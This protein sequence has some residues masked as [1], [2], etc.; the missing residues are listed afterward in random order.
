MDIHIGQETEIKPGSVLDKVRKHNKLKN[1]IGLRNVL[2]DKHLLEANQERRKNPGDEWS[3][4]RTRRQIL[5]IPIDLALA[6]EKIH[7]SEIWKDKKLLKK[8]LSE[9]EI[10]RRYLTVPLDTI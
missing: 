2:Q 8:V 10:A 5:E 6:L 1:V 9:D 3:K 7:G 4:M